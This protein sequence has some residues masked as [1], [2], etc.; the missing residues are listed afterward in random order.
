M[1]GSAAPAAVTAA[2]A[3]AGYAADPVD[4]TPH[5]SPTR[6]GGPPVD[7]TFFSTDITGLPEAIRSEVI[8]LDDGD[9]LLLRPG[10]VA[11]RLGDCDGAD[12][13]LQRLDPRPHAQGAAGL[14]GRRAR[15]QR[16]RPRHHRALARAAPGEPLR[17]GAARDPG[18]D[19]AGRGVHLPH[20]VPRPGPVLVPPAHPRGRHPGAGP[21]RQHRGRAGRAGLLAAGAPGC[22]ADSRRPAARGRRDRPVQPHRDQLRGDGPLRQRDAH[23]R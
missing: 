7:T 21:V 11:K 6:M 8:E 15:R 19:P 20:P 9:E 14:G 5:P 1:S 17:R 13:R 12:A 23:R 16:H 2:L 3:A 18:A 10:P 22:R 4:G